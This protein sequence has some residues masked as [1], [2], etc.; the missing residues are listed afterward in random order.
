MDVFDHAVSRGMMT[1]KA[2][3]GCLMAKHQQLQLLPDVSS[4]V[5]GTDTALRI[6]RW[7]RSSR[8]DTDLS[9]LNKTSFVKALMPFLVSEGLDHITWEW[10]SRTV[11]DTSGVWGDEERYQRASLLLVEL[12]RVK[13]QPQYG[14]LDAA[15]TTLLEAEKSFHT[16]P[17]LAKM[18]LLPWRSVSW[19]S[20]VE[21]YSRTAPS[22]QLFDAHVAAAHSL[23]TPVDV[24]KAHLHLY[25]PTHPDHSAALRLFENKQKVR[26]LVQGITPEKISIAK[27]NS[28]GILQWIAVLGHDTVNFLTRSGRSQEAEHVK[29]L[30]QAELASLF[31]HPLKPA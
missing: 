24:E 30:L 15:I 20:T 1:L 7:L 21:S 2:A 8:P 18:L 5:T 28:L 17:L 16:N 19:L 6:V 22:E 12:V 9:F 4:R 29:A 31:T 27:S 26:R 11:N 3:T 14:N 23:R 25:H 10:V 13:S